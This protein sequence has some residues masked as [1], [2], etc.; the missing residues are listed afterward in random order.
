MSKR[1]GAL[2]ISQSPRHDL[3]KPLHRAFPDFEI[4]EAGALDFT[5]TSN[6]PDGYDAY[7]PLTTTLINGDVV[8]LD[9]DFLTPLV[10][11]ALV[12]LERQVTDA[13]ILLCAGDFPD[14]TGHN[15][16]NPTQTAHNIL[17]AM[18]MQNILVISPIELQNKPITDKWVNADFN[19]TVV[20]MPTNSDSNIR[21]EWINEQ[22]NDKFNGVILDYVGYPIEEIHKLQ[23][24][25]NK[26][27][28][29]L[30]QLAIAA[31]QSVMGSSK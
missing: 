19:P 5:D 4:I 31:L 14:V 22:L 6:L 13:N 16:V 26:P 2:T 24:A 29:E 30:G 17:Q 25:I 21:I 27:L 8:T 11:T 15:L 1:I 20:T 9:R 18:N 28:F 10:Q 12:E 7:Y 3:L 23:K